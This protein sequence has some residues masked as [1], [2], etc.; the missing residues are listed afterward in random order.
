E[1]YSSLLEASKMVVGSK[2]S[3][4]WHSVFHDMNATRVYMSVFLRHIPNTNPQNI[5]NLSSRAMQEFHGQMHLFKNELKRWS[6]GDFSVVVAVPSKDRAEKVQSILADYDVEARISEHL[7]LPVDVPTIV[8]ANMTSGI[9]LP[10]HKL[11]VITENELFK[12]RSKRPRKK[13]NISNAE[14]IQN[15]QELKVGDYVVHTNH[16]IGRYLGIETL[17]VNG[18]HKDYM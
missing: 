2:F 9:E 15:Y 6:K 1:W 16:G 5:V 7:Q 11:V 10:M 12:K 8:V 4:D 14:R 3:F 13:Q 18:K 17:E